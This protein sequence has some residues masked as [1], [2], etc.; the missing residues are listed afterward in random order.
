MIIQYNRSNYTDLILATKT[1]R[2][3]Y[4]IMNLVLTNADHFMMTPDDLDSARD[5]AL[6]I[7]KL[8]HPEWLDEWGNLLIERVS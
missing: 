5:A 2:L 7:I 3:E 8:E 4:M 1:L 6:K